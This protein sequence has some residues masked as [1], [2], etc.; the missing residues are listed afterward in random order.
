[1]PGAAYFRSLDVEAAAEE[2][3]HLFDVLIEGADN[4]FSEEGGAA[5]G[6]AFH[7]ADGVGFP[8]AHLVVSLVLHALVIRIRC[9]QT[10][11]LRQLREQLPPD[12]TRKQKTEDNQGDEGNRHP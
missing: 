11:G 5:T 1:M 8:A 6:L 9:H 10:P 12:K 4:I 2:Q 3:E 7:A